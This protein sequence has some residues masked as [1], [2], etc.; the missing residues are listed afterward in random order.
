MG[1]EGVEGRCKPSTADPKPPNPLS[2]PEGAG[3]GGREAPQPCGIKNHPG[4]M[5]EA[6]EDVEALRQQLEEA[7]QQVWKCE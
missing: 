7:Q 3:A 6:E 1:I 2:A 4:R 5:Q